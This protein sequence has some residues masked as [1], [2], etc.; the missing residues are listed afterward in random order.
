PP[1]Q[2][3][4]DRHA[5]HPPPAAS[6]TAS[7]GEEPSRCTWCPARARRAPRLMAGGTLPPPSNVTNRNLPVR[8]ASAMA[9]PRSLRPRRRGDVLVEAKEVLWVEFPLQLR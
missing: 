4:P 9:I 6:A 8:F 3:E 7:I 5:R 2:D 1:G